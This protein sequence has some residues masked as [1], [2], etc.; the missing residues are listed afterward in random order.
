V[1]RAGASVRDVDDSLGIHL[2]RVGAGAEQIDALA[3][4]NGGRVG[5]AG[6]LAAP[7]R[8]ATRSRSGRVLGRD[9][10]RAYS[11][12]RADSA[13]PEWF[14]QGISSSADSSADGTVEGRRLLVVAWYSPAPAAH[15]CRVTFVDLET[16]RYRHVTVVRP[17]LTPLRIHAGGV[18]WCGRYLHLAAT[19]KGFVTCHLDDIV[20][21]PKH[22]FVLPVR[23]DYRAAAEK[24]HARMRY[25]FLSLDRWSSPPAM[26]A[27]E[28]GRPGDTTRF[29]RFEIDPDT[30]LLVSGADGRAWPAHLDDRG[31]VQMQGA[32][33]ARETYVV[34]VSHGPWAP[35]SLY[36]GRPGRFRERKLA[37]PMG[38]ED[39]TYSGPDDLI[40]SVTEHPRRRWFFSMRRE[41]LA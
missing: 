37:V 21:T 31:L 30:G 10:H 14:P 2:T 9:V 1:T 38:P 7:G 13:D 3:E 12:D 29:A 27:G 40:W 15:G 25:S 23:Y 34:T 24:G 6:V 17:D 32:V 39:L 16:L 22:G 35:G 28:Y 19:A 36:V 4:R 18:V 11:W 20:H 41:R 5:L 33:V 8:R 26:V